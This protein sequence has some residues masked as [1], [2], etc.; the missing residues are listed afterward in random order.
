MRRY[1]TQTTDSHN[2][3]IYPGHGRH[4]NINLNILDFVELLLS[5]S[6]SLIAAD[7]VITIAS[8]HSEPI[9]SANDAI[10]SNNIELRNTNVRLRMFVANNNDPLNDTRKY[11]GIGRLFNDVSMIV[12]KKSA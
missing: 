11:T 9:R 4:I 6:S 1:R 10:V 3:N 12:L 8:G 5:T 2:Y 7:D